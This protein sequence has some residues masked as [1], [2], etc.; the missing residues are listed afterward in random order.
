MKE[1]GEFRGV[2]S[3]YAEFLA[4]AFMPH[5]GEGLGR[6]DREAV[7]Q[8]I[9]GVIVGLE[10]F[11]RMLARLSAHCDKLKSNDVDPVGSQHVSKGCLSAREALT[12]VRATDTTRRK[13]IGKA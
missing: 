9:I 7:E 10:K 6:F 3:G 12:H 13:I 8:E 2:G 5:F 4:D 11:C 1:F